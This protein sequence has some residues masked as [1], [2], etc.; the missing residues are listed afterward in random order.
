[1]LLLRFGVGA[2]DGLFRL[3][4]GHGGHGWSGAGCGM[5][6]PDAH[7]VGQPCPQEARPVADGLPFL[8]L[9]VADA[10]DFGVHVHVGEVALQ[11]GQ[12]VQGRG[13]FFNRRSERSSLTLRRPDRSFF[14]PFPFRFPGR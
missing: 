5:G 11:G 2:E 4:G 13:R 7:G 8:C 12:Q 9:P 3:D 10:D 6:G 1:M 14:F